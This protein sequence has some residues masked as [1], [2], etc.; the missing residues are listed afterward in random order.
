MTRGERR[1]TLLGE[2]YEKSDN[3]SRIYLTY[4]QAG[5]LM[6]S[7]EKAEK[8][9]TMLLQLLRRGP[10]TVEQLATATELTPNAVRFHLASM[11]AAGEV[12]TAGVKRHEG[13]GKPAALY[14]LTPDAEMAFSKAY[15]PVLEACIQELR[16]SIPRKEVAPF[17]R[18]VGAR[19]AAATKKPTGPLASRVTRG[20]NL[21]NDLGGCTTVTKGRDGFS[22][23]GIGCCPLGAVVAGEP[24]VCEAV[25]SLLTSVIGATVRQC[26][27]HGPRPSCCF[28]IAVEAQQV[29]KQPH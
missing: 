19:L 18:R 14:V 3:K 25:E 7:I 12:E 4:Y 21:M 22:I 8:S 17:L 9:R 6:A 15:A 11:E 5:N 10:A 1:M 23:V 26:C 20:S 2:G 27:N 13:A 28:Q 29:G 24:C 16:E